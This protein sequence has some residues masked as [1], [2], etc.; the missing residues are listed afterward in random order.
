MGRQIN[1]TIAEKFRFDKISNHKSKRLN[2]PQTALWQYTS[3]SNWWKCLT[4][5]KI[6]SRQRK[7]DILRIGKRKLKWP[8][9][10]H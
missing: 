2:K 6:K 9:N 5:K 4:K 8:L 10:S 1:K 3:Y 7:I